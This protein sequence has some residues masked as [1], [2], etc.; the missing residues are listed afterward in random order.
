ML[1]TQDT[2][3]FALGEGGLTALA[4][5]FPAPQPEPE[6]TAPAPEPTFKF[7][8]SLKV[9]EERAKVMLDT[10][11][12][13][14]QQLKEEMGMN[15]G[16]VLITGG[17]MFLRWQNEQSYMGD[18]TWR[19]A[20]GNIFSKHNFTLGSPVRHTRYM[21]ARVTDDLV[22]STPFFAAMPASSR[23]NALAQQVE[24][25][26]QEKIGQ[27][28]ARSTIRQAQKSA[29]IRNE[30]TVKTAY[31]RDTS[32]WVGSATVLVDEK[33]QPVLTPT[34]GEYIFEDDNFLPHPSVQGQE[35]LEKDAGFVIIS[36]EAIN[37]I[38]P[39]RTSATVTNGD[40]LQAQPLSRVQGQPSQ[41][42]PELLGMSRPVYAGVPQDASV[43]G[44]S[45]NASQREIVRQGVP[46]QGQ[47]KAGELLGMRGPEQPNAPLGLQQTSAS[48]M[49][50]PIAPLGGAPAIPDGTI[51]VISDGQSRLCRFQQFDDLPQ[52][53]TL[54]DNVWMQG[55]DY[56]AFLCGLTYETIH[57]APV[58]AHLYKQSPSKLRQRYAN[59]D[60]GERYFSWY[61]ET[62][63]RALKPEQGESRV[64]Q[65]T[66]F[67]EVT[68][69][70][71]YMRWDADEDGEDEELLLVIDLQHKKLIYA[72]YL[73]A[74]YKRRPFS[75]IPGVERI[76]NRWYGRGIFSLTFDTTIAEDAQLNRGLLQNS[77]SSF[78]RWYNPGAFTALKDGQGPVLGTDEFYQVAGTWDF[79]KGPPMG[80]V[81][82]FADSEP[83]LELMEVMR[84]SSDAMVGAISLKDAS[85]SDLNQSKTATG[86]VNLQTASDVITKAT[87]LDQTE[88]IEDILD[89]AVMLILENLKDTELLVDEEANLLQTINR[90]EARSVTRDVRLTLTKSKSTQMVQIN[91]E[92]LKVQ[93]AYRQMMLTDPE[94]AM[95]MRQTM[96]NQLRG[97]E[98][99]DPETALPEITPEQVKAWQ[100]QQANAASQSQAKPP[101]ESISIKLPDLVGNE[102]VQALQ[103]FGIQADMKAWEDAQMQER[104][105]E[106]AALDAKSKNTPTDGK[107][108][109]QSSPA[110]VPA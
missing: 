2:T 84:Q 12:K 71:V 16:G 28:N 79:S 50:V 74:H 66:I 86:I 58:C 100:Q 41:V 57:E 6:P 14:V 73:H 104:A 37:N 92:V 52:R 24:K 5:Q 81:N 40:S 35:V 4:G 70:E 29:L 105:A 91:Q 94:G 45:T 85:Q 13:A 31:L 11:T 88:A 32:P 23:K 48:S 78:L 26:T 27:S 93:M 33:Q 82:L 25:K 64:G 46:A 72:N 106:Q 63:D 87:E 44:G 103:K 77:L 67:E 110:R 101:S 18:N 109:A 10:A 107:Q 30:C 61:D 1:D 55:L 83:S 9:S 89:I 56:R 54:Y 19:V 3:P 97:Y 7:R 49:A 47:D 17:W 108:P 38:V 42:G 59:V 8:T 102:R 98:V 39:Q 21:S 68:V 60:V 90:N 75:V 22:G 95:M 62:G 69:A 36:P 34:H 51:I 65:N 76:P 99:T 20:M 80:S 96:I 15:E 43:D 53:E